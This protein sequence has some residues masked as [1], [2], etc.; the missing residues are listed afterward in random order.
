METYD[1]EV[2]NPQQSD[3]LCLC[4]RSTVNVLRRYLL[5]T[6]S[7]GKSFPSDCLFTALRFDNLLSK[8]PMTNQLNKDVK[9]I[10]VNEAR[11]KLITWFTGLRD[12][13]WGGGEDMRNAT[14][15]IHA[16]L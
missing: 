8:N 7:Y 3:Q 1:A 16:E 9:S 12:T 15:V 10:H 11:Y 2:V 13:K 4:Q 14:G 5:E 6:A